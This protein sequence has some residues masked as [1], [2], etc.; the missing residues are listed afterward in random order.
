[1]N[2]YTRGIILA[3]ARLAVCTVV[4]YPYGMS[5]RHCFGGKQLRLYY[6]RNRATRCA[7][8]RGAR[9][10]PERTRGTSTTP[11]SATC[12]PQRTHAV[13]SRQASAAVPEALYCVGTT[14]GS[15]QTGGRTREEKRPN[16][17]TFLVIRGLPISPLFAS[18]PWPRHTW[19][20]VR[21][22]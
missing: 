18:W 1:M 10:D 21:S 6:G 8:M 9:G 4:A 12:S 19:M 13:V 22:S 15:G 16:C 2:T 20:P 14:P 17:F 7:G 3:L 11:P 5:R